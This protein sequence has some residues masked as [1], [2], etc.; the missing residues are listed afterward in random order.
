MS[1]TPSSVRLPTSIAALPAGAVV[2]TSSLRRQ[3]QVKAMRRDLQVVNFRGN[4]E[5]RL[6]K[7]SEGVAAATFL[8]FAGLKRLGRETVA[9]RVMAIDEMLPAVAQGAIGIEIRSADGRMR[10]LLLPLGH[11]PTRAAVTAERAF[12]R[13][14]DGSCRTPIAGHARF[15]GG[16]VRFDGEILTPDGATTHRTIRRGAAADAVAMAVDAADEL[17][18]RAGPEFF[19]ALG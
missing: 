10:E 5:T 15:N 13:R 12:L 6:R 14:L 9:T 16:E 1:A 19:R 4:V 2:G 8:A 18:G 17:L 11:E 3:A 7:L